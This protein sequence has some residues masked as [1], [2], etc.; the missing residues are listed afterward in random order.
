MILALLSDVHSN[1]QALQACLRHARA[2][3]AGRIAFLGDLVGYGADPDAVVEIVM[4]EVQAGALAVKG[5]HDEAI[6]QGG[7]YMNEMARDSITWT[8]QT[9]SFKARE[10][11]AALPLM[12]REA[13]L[14][15]VHASADRPARWDYVDSPGA[16]QRSAAATDA[17]LTLSGHV[18]EQL[19]YFEAAPGKWS[20]FRPTPGKPVPVR[21]G[22]RWLAIV[23]STGQPRDGRPAAAYASFDT[24]R[25][26]LTFHRVAYDHLEAAARIRRAGLPEQLAY[27]VEKGI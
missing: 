23:G 1:L 20:L 19:L 7:Q 21:P 4:Q 2:N 6:E 10:F 11:L 22:R 5:N 24:E 8:R 27:R 15:L 16:A 25:A 3:G 18:H 26:Q 12:H 14:C 17:S 13:S 9:L